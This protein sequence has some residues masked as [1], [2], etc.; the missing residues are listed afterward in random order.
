MTL[1]DKIRQSC[2]FNKMAENR[3][4]VICDTSKCIF[5]GSCEKICQIDAIVVD[6]GEKDWILDH[7]TCIRCGHCLNVCPVHALKVQK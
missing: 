4:R 7:G 5:C 6:A 1:K 3:G 2:F